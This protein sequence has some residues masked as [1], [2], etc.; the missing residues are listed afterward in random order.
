MIC[1]FCNAELAD[2]TEL[3]PVCGMALTEETAEVV[4][5]ETTVVAEVTE[6]IPSDESVVA[7][8]EPEESEKEAPATEVKEEETCDCEPAENVKAP[9]N[10]KVWP[11]ILWTLASVLAL[12]VL[13]VVL[14]AALGVEVKFPTN[15]IYGKNQYTVSDEQAAEKGDTVVAK[16]GDAELTN[17]QLQIYYRM[18]VLDFVNYYGSYLSEVGFDYTQPLSSQISYMDDTMSWEQYFINAS[19]ES[20]SNYQALCLAAEKAGF[21]IDEETEAEI[22]KIP[23]SLEAQALEGGYESADAMIKEIL[24]PACDLETYM[25]YVRIDTL[26]NMYYSSEYEKL[27]PTDAEVEAYFDENQEAFAASQITKDGGLVSSVRH[28]LVCPKKEETAE[29]AEGAEGATDATEATDSGEYTEAEWA[30]CLAEAE[31]ILQ[32][33]KD[34]AATEESFADLVATY[35]EDPGSASTGG[36]YEDINPT[37]SYVE[38]FLNWSVDMTRQTGDT[39]IVQTEYGYHIM[40][41]VSGKPYWQESARTQLLSERTDKMLA[42]IKESYPSK[43]TY[44]K[45][46]LSELELA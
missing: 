46:A 16:V 39:G 27:I 12:G 30:A 25:N 38:N 34:G 29:G 33:W 11:V 24:G 35:T 5:E 9:A 7:E 21:K 32:E 37:S 44:K 43:V 10:R 26:A 31:R 18:R 36:L 40:Y 13:A 2:G 22:A 45:I 23:E 4:A 41:F 17:A 8:N 1:K 19:I 42:E 28:I 20:W 6:E 14:L 15:D 3:C